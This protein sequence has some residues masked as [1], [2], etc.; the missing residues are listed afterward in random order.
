MTISI[1]KTIVV[2]MILIGMLLTSC[3]GGEKRFIGKHTINIPQLT[4]NFD[5]SKDI[6]Q[7]GLIDHPEVKYYDIYK[8]SIEIYKEGEGLAGQFKYVFP[9]NPTMFSRTTSISEHNC[10]LKNIHLVGDTLFFL[11]IKDNNNSYDGNMYESNGKMIVGLPKN[12][13]NVLPPALY[14]SKLFEEKDGILYFPVDEMVNKNSFYTL[15]VDS[16][17]RLSASNGKYK[18]MCTLNIDYLKKLH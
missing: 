10:L 14:T 15:Q 18:N 4:F 17:E 9:K 1:K 6:I 12:I 2:S 13:Y 7:Y 11:V 8:S 5:S 3:G 16:M